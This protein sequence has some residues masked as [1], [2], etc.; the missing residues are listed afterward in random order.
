[1]DENVKCVPKDINPPNVPQ[2]PPIENF[3]GWLAQQVYEEGWEAKTEQHLIRRIK[4]KMKE[5]DKN[6]V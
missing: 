1:M 4:S 2:A 6:F 3:W 5:F